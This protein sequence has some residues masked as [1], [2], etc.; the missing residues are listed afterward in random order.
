MPTS[1]RSRRSA[2]SW[3]GRR[4]A[5]RRSSQPSS[6]S[7]RVSARAWTP[8]G[9]RR[10]EPTCPPAIERRRTGR[11]R[12]SPRRSGISRRSGFV[13][14][15]SGEHGSSTKPTG[16]RRGRPTSRSCGSVGGSS[17][18]PPGGAT[19]ASRTTSCWRSTPAWPSGRGCIRRLACAWRRSKGSPIAARSPADGCSTSVAARASSRSRRSSWARR[20]RSVSTPTRSRSRPP[21]PTGG[22]MPSPGACALAREPCRART[23]PLTSSSPT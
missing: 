2:R 11:R 14:S 10:S 6:S 12:A 21:S 22:A 3:A 5:G 19:V 8:A 4:R 17:S 1:R 18:G 13:R 15:A 9:R 20:L 16:P 7:T 23:S